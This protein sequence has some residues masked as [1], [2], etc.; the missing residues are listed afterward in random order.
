MSGQGKLQLEQALNSPKKFSLQQGFT[1]YVPLFS[2][3][4]QVG[5][6][7]PSSSCLLHDTHILR[8]TVETAA[9]EAL[10]V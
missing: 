7:C 8:A 6:L 1:E 5:G 4:G 2:S 9:P 10:Q 3:Y